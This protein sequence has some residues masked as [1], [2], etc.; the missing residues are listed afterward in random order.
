MATIN[1]VQDRLSAGAHVVLDDYAFAGHEAQ[2]RAWNDYARTR[3]RAILTLPTG[4][5]LMTL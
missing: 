1:A 5:G 3:Q 2:Y 4:Q